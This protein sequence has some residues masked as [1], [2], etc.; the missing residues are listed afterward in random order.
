MK[1][2]YIFA[3]LKYYPSG[4][5]CDLRAKV[6]TDNLATARSYAVVFQE[7]NDWWHIVDADTLTIV[8]KWETADLT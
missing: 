2:F 7:G 4:G 6:T 5:W 8:D 1:T 3:A